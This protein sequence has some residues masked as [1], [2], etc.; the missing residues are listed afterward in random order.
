M[1][2]HFDHQVF[3]SFRLFVDNR[4]AHSG[5]AY[6][7]T[8]GRF[9]PSVSNRSGIFTYACPY[10]GLIND[11]SVSGANVMSGVY[12]NGNYISVGTSGLQEINH[13]AGTVSFSYQP[14]PANI[15]GSFSVKEVAVETSVSKEDSLVFETKFFPQP[16]YSQQFTG[17]PQ[18]SYPLPIVFLKNRGSDIKPFAI[19]GTD[20]DEKSI[21]AIVIADNEFALDAVCGILR[22]THYRRFSFVTPPLNVRGGYTGTEYNYSRLASGVG[23]LIKSVSVS[24]IGNG[25]GMHNNYSVAFVDF[26]INH[27]RDH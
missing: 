15:T 8:T 22:D 14:S 2:V 18:N 16:K 7:N 1:R 21:R 6:F 26:K 3:S 20:L 24:Y 25:Q 19:G 9:Y 27:V 12:L 10:K 4:I 23:P 11:S 17:I 5:Q 13:Y